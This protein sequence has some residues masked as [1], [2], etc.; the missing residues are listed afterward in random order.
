MLGWNIQGECCLNRKIYL[1]LHCHI[2]IDLGVNKGIRGC[3]S[4]RPLFCVVCIEI[5]KPHLFAF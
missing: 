3:I 4:L 1:Y 2:K 5:V